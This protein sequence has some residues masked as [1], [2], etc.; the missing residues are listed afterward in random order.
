MWL[1]LLLILIGILLVSYG[2]RWLVGGASSLA[3]RFRVSDL[4]IG[5]TVVSFGTSAPELTVSVLAALNGTADVAIGNVI[6]SNT[7][8]M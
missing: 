2:A 4:V 5:L 3:K 1:N 8:N 7:L 6:G